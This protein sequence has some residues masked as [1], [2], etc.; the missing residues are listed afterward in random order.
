[1]NDLGNVDDLTTLASA[2]AGAVVEAMAGD[3]WQAARDTVAGL[4]HTARRKKAAVRARLDADAT[5]LASVSDPS[6]ASSSPAAEDARSALQAAWASELAALLRRDLAYR[7]PLT[8]LVAAYG[9]AA[10]GAAPG[11]SG[12]VHTPTERQTG[13]RN[14]TQKQTNIAR[15]RGTVL[16]VQAGDIHIHSVASNEPRGESESR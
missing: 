11:P 10:P 9:T 1:M 16:G 13:M 15:G 12:F 7:G 6:S 8:D 3:A 2:A 5:L 14:R 4:F